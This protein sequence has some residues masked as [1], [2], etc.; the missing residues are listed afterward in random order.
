MPA[1]SLSIFL[2]AI[3]TCLLAYR[4]DWLN[5]YLSNDNDKAFIISEHSCSLL[6]RIAH[7]AKEL[8]TRLSE[9]TFGLVGLD[10]TLPFEKLTE[11]SRDTKRYLAF[12][13]LLD[14]W[15]M[16]RPRALEGNLIPT[17]FGDRMFYELS[18]VD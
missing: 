17:T 18:G 7:V 2:V 16:W 8:N 4:P 11:I 3:V 6:C 14:C 1:S 10:F 5:K 9:N 12:E 15:I 13:C